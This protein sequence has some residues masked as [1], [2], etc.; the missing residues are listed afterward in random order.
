[1]GA[2]KRKNTT[3]R[4][5]RLLVRSIVHTA[6]NHQLKKIAIHLGPMGCPKLEKLGDEWFY[7]T[8]GENLSLATYEF[9]TYKTKKDTQ[10]TLTD[11]LVCGLGSKA[12]KAFKKGLIIAEGANYARDIANTA[13][14]DMK[15]SDLAKAT[16]KALKGTD[17]KVRILDHKTILKL[18]MGLL[19]A[20][21]KGASDKP[22]FI[23]IEYRG[24]P[25]QAKTGAISA[26]I[27]LLGKGIT[28]DT[29][30]LNIKPTGHMHD[31]HMD[32]SGGAAI[33]GAL[34]TIAKLKLKKN[35]IGIIPAAENA[36]SDRSM[37][38]GD[39]VT[40]MSGLTVEVMHTD[41]E[42][43]MVLADGLTYIEKNYNAKVV[44]DVATL[45]GASLVAVGQQASV[46]LTKDEKLQNTLVTLGERSG[47]LLWPL[48]LWDE[49]KKMLKSSRADLT[50]IEANFSRNAGCIEGG[51][52]L[53]FFAPKKIPWAHIDMAPRMDSIPDDKLAKG[54]TGEPVRLLVAFV[55]NY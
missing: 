15:P 4:S 40:S 51:T 7:Q 32:M 25:K 44:L 11:I 16:Q 50:N 6:K 18:K 55:E 5:F 52:F 26:P 1:M 13:G 10:L 30:G 45:T 24:A 29:G 49:Y 42:G 33:I 12:E 53:S 48:P 8:L 28:Y 34:R 38:A 19:D 21:G 31:M 14:E 35:V 37:R 22:R 23:I 46:V 41:A 54:A 27:V 17:A 2:G 39:I 43:R 47:D 20:V 3:A 36:V 9:N